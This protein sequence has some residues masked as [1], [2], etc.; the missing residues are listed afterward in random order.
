MLHNTTMSHLSVHLCVS[1]QC[2]VCVCALEVRH[3]S[4]NCITHTTLEKD[5]HH[6]SHYNIIIFKEPTTLHRRLH[7][8]Y[9]G[10]QLSRILSRIQR[11]KTLSRWTTRGKVNWWLFAMRHW[12]LLSAT[13]NTI[14]LCVCVCVCV[15]VF[16]CMY[17]CSSHSKRHCC[18]C[19]AHP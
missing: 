18:C 8:R 16:W 4:E 10:G 7:S 13:T 9:F 14:C 17:V 11:R 3:S 1:T 6:T 19:S 5:A 2:T 12:H 15:P